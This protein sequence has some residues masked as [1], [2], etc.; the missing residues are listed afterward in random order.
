M[1]SKL[2]SQ[3]RLTMPQKM[4][5]CIAVVPTR[6]HAF[7]YNM[8]SQTVSPLILGC[9]KDFFIVLSSMIPTEILLH[10]P[11]LNAIKRVTKLSEGV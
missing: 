3:H 10:T 8:A 9:E 11:L 1:H 2:H 4:D 5:C 6:N 7:Q